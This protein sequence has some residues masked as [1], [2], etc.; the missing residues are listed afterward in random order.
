MLVIPRSWTTAATAVE[1]PRATT[2]SIVLDGSGHLKLVD[3]AWTGFSKSLHS[4]RATFDLP[5]SLSHSCVVQFFQADMTM[6]NRA[7]K[8]GCTAFTFRY[9]VR[10]D[11]MGTELDAI[12]ATMNDGMAAWVH[13]RWLWS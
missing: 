11:V 2:V 1:E 10:L 8:P 12:A 7:Q 3:L 4:Q 5:I 6:C 9:V 13:C